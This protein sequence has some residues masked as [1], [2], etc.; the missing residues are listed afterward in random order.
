MNLNTIV[1]VK[2]PKSFEEIEWR[3]GHAFLGG[4]TWLFS[5]PQVGTDTLV[6]LERLGWPP[7]TETPS[8]LEIAATSRP[9]GFTVSAGQPNCWRSTSVSVL[10]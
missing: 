8:G 1:D 3:D 4:G 10:T 6:D 2:R 7:L 9:S 5:E